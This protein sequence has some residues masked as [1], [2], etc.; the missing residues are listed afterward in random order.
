[1]SE[2]VIFYF[3]IAIAITCISTISLILHFESSSPMLFEAII[4]NHYDLA[5]AFH[6]GKY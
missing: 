1:M 5:F 4:F 3:I 2:V 6:L